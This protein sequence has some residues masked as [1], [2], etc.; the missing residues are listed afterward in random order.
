[1]EAT[2]GEDGSATHRLPTATHIVVSRGKAQ[3]IRSRIYKDLTHSVIFRLIYLHV[4]QKSHTFAR[5]KITVRG[6]TKFLTFL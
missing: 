2:D 3:R 6:S 5:G 4:S 1:M